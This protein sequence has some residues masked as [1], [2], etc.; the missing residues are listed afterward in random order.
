[1]S[2]PFYLF[3]PCIPPEPIRG[4][5]FRGANHKMLNAGCHEGLVG[6][7]EGTGISLGFGH[8]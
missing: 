7:A 6:V 3:N 5:G 1:M 2:R 8:A 4:L